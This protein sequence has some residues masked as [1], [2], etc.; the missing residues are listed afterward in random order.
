MSK[1]KS[2]SKTV[3]VKAKK[4]PKRTKRRVRYVEA[5]TAKD[6]NPFFALRVPGALLRAFKAHAR[7]SKTEPTMMV[8]RYMSK[9]TG[10]ALETDGAE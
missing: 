9:V 8:R 2:K 5:P 6:G 7:K 10:V 3:S 1:S 4:V